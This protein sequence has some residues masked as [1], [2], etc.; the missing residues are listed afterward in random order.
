MDVFFAFACLLFVIGLWRF[1]RKWNRNSEQLDYL[2]SLC[3]RLE[4]DNIK[5]E[6]KIKR[7]RNTV[8]SLSKKNYIVTAEKKESEL[9]V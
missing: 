5:I 8:K 7:L 9:I 4:S 2:I 6:V 1:D 3:E